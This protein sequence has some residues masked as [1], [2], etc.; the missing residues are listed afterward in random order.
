[1]DWVDD[2]KVLACLVLEAAE[3][4][5]NFYG[6]DMANIIAEWGL[7]LDGEAVP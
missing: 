3:L 1:M 4:A 5:T 6:D 7:R 2:R